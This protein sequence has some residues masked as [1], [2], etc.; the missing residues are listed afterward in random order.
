MPIPRPNLVQCRDC[1]S[2]KVHPVPYDAD[3][4]YPNW[5]GWFRIPTAVSMELGYPS[6]AMVA[7]Q[8][9]QCMRCANYWA[10]MQEVTDRTYW[11]SLPEYTP[12]NLKVQ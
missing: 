3:P 4:R 2:T 9:Y 6:S 10:V 7:T 8:L 12:K 11:L 1:G 5:D